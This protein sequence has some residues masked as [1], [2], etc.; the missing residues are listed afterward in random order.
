MELL[1]QLCEI[2]APAGSEAPLT[3]FVL[4]YIHTFL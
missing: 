3:D 1:K 4:N 2:H